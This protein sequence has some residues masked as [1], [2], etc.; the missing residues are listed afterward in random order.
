MVV[1]RRSFP[2]GFPPCHHLLAFATRT[3]H[4]NLGCPM[5]DATMQCEKIPFFESMSLICVLH[6]T[7]LSTL[8]TVHLTIFSHQTLRRHTK[9]WGGFF[10]S[11]PNLW[12]EKRKWPLLRPKARFF[13][14]PF[15]AAYGLQTAK[16]MT[17]RNPKRENHLGMYK[18]RKIMWINYLSTGRILY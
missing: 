16:L 13:V 17:T 9:L 7:L 14:S 12:G 10:W 11:Q 5:P 1:G 8:V 15:F 18:T 2:I 6:F 3:P 4:Q